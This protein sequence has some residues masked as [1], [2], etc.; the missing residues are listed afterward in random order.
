M[1]VV[2]L[3]SMALLAS[4]QAQAPQLPH[5]FYG[6]LTIGGAPAPIG[7]V[8]VANV[9]GVQKGSLV[10][11]ES[12]LY[13][14]PSALQN[15]LA[16]QGGITPG[17]TI[18]FFVDGVL[19]NETA[20]FESGA[21]TQ[22]NLTVAGPPPEATATPAPTATTVPSGGSGEGV[23]AQPQPTATEPP[24]DGG[25]TTLPTAQDIALL[26]PE[27]AADLISSVEPD[28]AAG[29]LAELEPDDAA[30]IIQEVEASVAAELISTTAPDVAAAIIE[31]M[32]APT[33]VELVE[34][35]SQVKLVERLPELSVGKLSEIP[36]QLLFDKLPTVS[37]SHLALETPPQVEPSLPQ[38]AIVQSTPSQITFAAE[39]RESL[40]T[41]L[42]DTSGSSAPT[43]VERILGRF[44]RRLTEVQTTLAGLDAAPE[45]APPLPG[46]QI[47]SSLFSVDLLGVAP[48]DLSVVHLTLFI[49]EA[50]LKT[51]GVHKWSIQFNRFD[52]QRGVWVPYPSKRVA[53]NEDRHL[54][55]VAL[56]G[57]SDIAVT[58]QSKPPGTGHPGRRARD[59]TAGPPGRPGDHDQRP[60]YEPRLR[61]CRLPGE[62][63]AR[64]NDRGHSADRHRTGSDSAG[65]VHHQQAVGR[66][67]RAGR[68]AAG[69]VRSSSGTAHDTAAGLNYRP[70][71]G[72]PDTHPT[73]HRHPS[74]VAGP[75]DPY[76]TRGTNTSADRRPT[77]H[78][79]AHGSPAA[80]HSDTYAPAR[81]NASA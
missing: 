18:E 43:P 80:G 5:L 11:T 67:P 22:L 56:T 36:A 17:S 4:V 41:A 25:E 21:V 68:T 44:T 66:L 77:T 40:W 78:T 35:M 50:W 63:V 79:Y 75:H 72:V 39:T 62:P 3:E 33:V 38:P 74:P 59:R 23:P 60:G 48:E 20:S 19:A 81:S 53:E 47:V 32:D 37:V 71:A 52:E 2:L 55:S 61:T 9:G 49:E 54:Y 69:S 30:G 57:F 42:T 6:T 58:G 13:G 12:G 27:D 29:I 10:T 24:P 15:K 16:V 7:T 31:E 28:Q 45:D 14:G 65:R 1:V 8:V 73:T 34:A 26:S 64:R 76:I 70:N 51:N 46:D